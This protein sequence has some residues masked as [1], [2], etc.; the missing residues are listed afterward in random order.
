MVAVSIEP[1]SEDAPRASEGVALHGQYDGPHGPAFIGYGDERQTT[2]AWGP[3]VPGACVDFGPAGR[4]DGKP[5]TSFT[6]PVALQ[7]GTLSGEVAQ[8]HWSLFSRRRRGMVISLGPRSYLYRVTGIASPLVERED[9][10]PVARLGGVFGPAQVAED[11]DEVDLVVA[12][13]MIYG[14]AVGELTVQA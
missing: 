9:R 4:R 1:P 13:V 14:V 10:T 5:H 2:R 8:P 3:H 6:E 12:L 11:A 7:V